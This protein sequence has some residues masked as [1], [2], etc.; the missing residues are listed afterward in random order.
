MFASLLT[1]QPRQKNQIA[2]GVTKF[3]FSEVFDTKQNI[4]SLPVKSTNLLRQPSETCIFEV[5][6]LKRTDRLAAEMKCRNTIILGTD[7][8]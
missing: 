6:A 3:T 2:D 4:A 1:F 7:K 5:E 8:H